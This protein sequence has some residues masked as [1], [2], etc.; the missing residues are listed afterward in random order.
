MRVTVNE[1]MSVNEAVTVNITIRVTVN[2]TV[3]VTVNEAVTQATSRLPQ[4]PLHCLPGILRREAESRVLIRCVFA[5]C[6]IE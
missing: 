1:A 5:A 3:G 6:I 2:E 4:M